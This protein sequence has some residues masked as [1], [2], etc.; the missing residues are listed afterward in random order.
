MYGRVQKANRQGDDDDAVDADDASVAGRT[1]E[2][3]AAEL[4]A[5]RN[6][7]TSRVGKTP[8]QSRVL[9]WSVRF[10]TRYET[11]DG[12]DLARDEGQPG[13]T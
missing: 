7:G 1:A 2:T 11:S 13:P 3:V 6:E 4:N 12:G 10:W 5:Y 9:S 8:R